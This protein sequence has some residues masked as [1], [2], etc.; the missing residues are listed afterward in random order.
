MRASA[1][2]DTLPLSGTKLVCSAGPCEGQEFALEDGEYVVGRSNDNP[3]CIPDT[4]VSRKHVLIRRLGGG[5]TANDLGSGN[6]TLLNGEPLTD[7]TP[8]SSGSVLTLGD[9]E[10]TFNDASNATMMMPMPPAPSSRPARR[11]T[12]AAAAPAAAPA[13]EE[14]PGDAIAPRRPAP[15]RPESRVRASRGRTAGPDPE[16]QKR[17][18]RLLLISA[19]VFVVLVGL[20]VAIKVKQQ[21]DADAWRAE[22][23]AAQEQREQVEGLFQDAKNLI[24]DGKWADAKTRLLE[25]QEAQPDHPQLQDYLTR[26]EKEIPNQAAIDAAK[27]ALEKDQLGTAATSLAKVSKDTQLFESM[28]TLRRTLQDKADKRAREALSMLEQKQIDQAKAITDDIL[29]AIPTHRDAKV[30]NEQAA[31]LIGIRDAPPPPP[32]A[33]PTVKP[34]D[35]A[36][37]RFRD[38]DLNGAMAMANACAGRS[39]QCKT[40]MTSLTDFGN[41]YKKVEELDVKGLSRLMDL[42]KKIT[43]GRSSKLI[44][45]A[46]KRAANLFYKM[47]SSAKVAGQWGRAMENAQRALQADPGHVGA[48]AIVTEM[49]GK[50]KDVYWGAYAIKDSSPE[51]ALPKFRDVVNM[52]PPDD[53]LHQKAKVWVEKLQR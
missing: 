48:S 44:G 5:W 21:Q 27:T 7:E 12:A 18:K 45:N 10:L 49:R 46:G 43:N 40:L 33:P 13:E 25:L 32:V 6:G 17:K 11:P 30:I 22:A 38:G 24:R 53:E 31:R 47:A 16:A 36:V 9:T 4:S 52:T 26:V 35:Q 51:D 39:P 8:L 2:P 20:L 15:S 34:W 14:E 28:G 19:G 41:L 37:E 42:D 50:A 3:I 29:V 1:A 23:L